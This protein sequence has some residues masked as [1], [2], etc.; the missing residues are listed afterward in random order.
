MWYAS[1]LLKTKSARFHFMWKGL[2][3]KHN[4]M[5]LQGKGWKWNAYQFP[6]RLWQRMPNV[7]L[8][9][10][11]LTFTDLSPVE[12]ALM[13]RFWRKFI[14]WS[15]RLTSDEMTV[16]TRLAVNR[17]LNLKSLVW[18]RRA[19]QNTNDSLDPVGNFKKKHPLLKWKL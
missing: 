1:H 11:L 2:S 17:W 13:P 19:F 8:S 4:G 14:W 3:R 12:V 16:V 15:Y 6:C 9:F 7:V 10:L 5:G 18:N